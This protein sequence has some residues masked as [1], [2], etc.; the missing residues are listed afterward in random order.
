MNNA[1]FFITRPR[2]RASD[3]E[4]S[5]LSDLQNEKSGLKARQILDVIAALRGYEGSTSA[6]LASLSGLDRYT[7]AR[8]LPDAREQLKTRNGDN[9]TCRISGRMAMTWYLI[10][11]G[12][13]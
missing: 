3:P 6:E 8:R 9:R 2:H 4:T 10:G 5:K 13:G 11:E 7:C 1:P 12:H